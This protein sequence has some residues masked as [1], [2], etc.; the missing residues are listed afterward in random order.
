MLCVCV[1]VCVSIEVCIAVCLC[2]CVSVCGE[3]S[4][5]VYTT[6]DKRMDSF[7]AQHTYIHTYS[8]LLG[9]TPILSTHSLSSF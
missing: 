6:N 4:E 3:N 1:C 8:T 2:E 7:K 5:P 9:H